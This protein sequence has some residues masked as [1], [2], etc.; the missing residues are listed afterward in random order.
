[1][2]KRE[3]FAYLAGV[4]DSDGSI[5]LLKHKDLKCKRGFTWYPRITITNTDKKILEFIKK[6]IGG[7]VS[8]GRINK[9]SFKSKKLI[10]QWNANS[11]LIRKIS[12]IL[13]EFLI[14]KKEQGKLLKEALEIIKNHR[15]SN[16]NLE[17]VDKKLEKIFNKIKKLNQ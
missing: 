14:T 11:N 6:E 4:I 15:L 5:L 3:F 2:I 8:K 10:Y 7:Y 12:D 17:E 16:Y 9:G 13:L 1:M